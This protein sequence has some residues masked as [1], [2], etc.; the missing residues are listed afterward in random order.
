MSFVLTLLIMEMA[1]FHSLIGLKL[2]SGNKFLRLSVSFETFI[3]DH[4]IL[5]RCGL[6]DGIYWGSYNQP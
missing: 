6:N 3:G 5:K 1:L 2:D 4:F